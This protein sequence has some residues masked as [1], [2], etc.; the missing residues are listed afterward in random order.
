MKVDFLTQT[1]VAAALKVS[2]KTI[3]NWTA[4]GMPHYRPIGGSPKY[5]LDECL[6]WMK[7]GARQEEPK[8]E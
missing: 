2:T 7:R 3:A 8:G 6:E 4:Q 1:E 5:I